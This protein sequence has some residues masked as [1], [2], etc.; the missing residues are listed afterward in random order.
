M[1]GSGKKLGNEEQGA[2]YSFKNAMIALR[3]E[4]ERWLKEGMRDD[5]FI[6]FGSWM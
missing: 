5:G 1:G 4:A 2:D 6:A 3:L